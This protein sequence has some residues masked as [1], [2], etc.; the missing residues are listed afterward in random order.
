MNGAEVARQIM[1]SAY[2]W[3]QGKI[4]RD[5]TSGAP[6]PGVSRRPDAVARAD[7]QDRLMLSLLN[8]CVAVLREGLVDSREMIDAGV[9]FGCGFAPFRGGPLQDA[10]TRGITTCV[11]R[12]EELSIRYGDRFKPDAGWSLSVEVEPP[13]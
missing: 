11:A 4:L 6:V 7:L 3:R 13:G 1:R 2:R 8:E 9:I 12:L 10:S 5:S